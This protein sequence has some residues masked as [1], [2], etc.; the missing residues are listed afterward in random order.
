MRSTKGFHLTSPR[1]SYIDSSHEDSSIV[2]TFATH[3]KHPKRVST[4]DSP[5]LLCCKTSH[6]LVVLSPIMPHSDLRQDFP[7]L[8]PKEGHPNSVHKISSRKHKSSHVEQLGSLRELVSLHPSLPQNH[9]VD[10]ALLVVPIF[11]LGCAP[12]FS[13]MDSKGRHHKQLCPLGV[14]HPI[15]NPCTH[16]PL[17]PLELTRPNLGA[18]I[19][20]APQPL[21]CTPTFLVHPFSWSL[22]PH[23]SPR[24]WASPLAHSHAQRAPLA[25]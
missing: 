19:M 13:Y 21:W 22:S 24:A 7:K 18:F 3:A 8:N 1:H 14:S 6:K 17:C 12:L 11:F 15:V 4:T 2:T 23:T 20:S 9:R 16:Q 10:L 5:S 25:Q